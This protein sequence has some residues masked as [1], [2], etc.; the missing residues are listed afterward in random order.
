MLNIGLIGLKRAKSA[1]ESCSCYR[2][3][4]VFFPVLP[5]GTTAAAERARTVA[6]SGEFFMEEA[7]TTSAG[8]RITL[9]GWGLVLESKIFSKMAAA[10]SPIN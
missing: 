4:A 5:F 10:R 3:L 9:T 2:R 1:R 8:S 7:R 6:R